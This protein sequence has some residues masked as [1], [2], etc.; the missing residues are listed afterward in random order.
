MWAIAILVVA[1][2]VQLVVITP[3]YFLKKNRRQAAEA[4]VQEFIRQMGRLDKQYASHQRQL[5]KDLNLINY[6]LK[7]GNDPDE[8]MSQDEK[9]ANASKFKQAPMGAEDAKKWTAVLE[10]DKFGKSEDNVEVKALRNGEF[11]VTDM[12]PAD[13]GLT[14]AAFTYSDDY[15]ENIY[16][17][18]N[19]EML[20]KKYYKYVIYFTTARATQIPMTYPHKYDGAQMLS[21]YKHPSQAIWFIKNWK[22]IREELE[23]HDDTEVY[24]IDD[25]ITDFDL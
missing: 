2:G 4:E 15:Y 7:T 12:E 17:C 18:I 6:W 24:E 20:E 9:D 1:V 25:S 23:R 22:R 11:T 21:L 8:V 14:E 3:M 13:A 10:A 16:Y 5:A 19:P